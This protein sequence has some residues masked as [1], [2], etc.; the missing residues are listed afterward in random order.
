MSKQK[1]QMKPKNFF[2][3]YFDQTRGTFTQEQVVQFAGDNLETESNILPL[4][5]ARKYFDESTGRIY[6]LFNS[7]LP[8]RVTSMSLKKLRRSVALNNLFNYDVTKP[9]DMFKLLPWVIMAMLIV[10]G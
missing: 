6:Y 10:F 3:M 4:E 2:V 7:E 5:N 9:F 8:E 1:K